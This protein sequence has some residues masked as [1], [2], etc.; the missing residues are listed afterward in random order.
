LS[1]KI[2]RAI[3]K[4]TG[5]IH[6]SRPIIKNIPYLGSTILAM[7]TSLKQANTAV[8]KVLAD[9]FDRMKNQ[10]DSFTLVEGKLEEFQGY[11]EDSV[12]YAD[13][14]R[15]NLQD[16]KYWTNANDC[17]LDNQLD[18]I[19]A[20]VNPS[21]VE[22]ATQIYKGCHGDV[23]IPSVE[24]PFPD[25]AL[26]EDIKRI[27]NE[28]SD[29][30]DKTIGEFL[31]GADYHQC[32]NP[33]LS[34]FVDLVGDISGLAMCPVTGA[35]N[36]VVSESLD[37]LLP[38]VSDD[39]VDVVNQQGE[40][41]NSSTESLNIL[42][43]GM[44]QFG[45]PRFASGPVF[46]AVCD[47]DV[48]FPWANQQ[49]YIKYPYQDI[50]IPQVLAFS[51]LEPPEADGSFDLSEIGGAIKDEC[52]GAAQAFTENIDCC[53]AA[54]I[55][56]HGA[57][58]FAHNNDECSYDTDCHTG[59]CAFVG[60]GYGKR[61]TNGKSGLYCGLDRHCDGEC[62]AL[63]VGKGSFCSDGKEG[64]YCGG[65]TAKDCSSGN[66]CYGP[67]DQCYNGSDGDPCGVHGDCDSNICNVGLGSKCSSGAE[68]TTCT[69]QSDCASGNYCFSGKCYN[70]R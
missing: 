1:K 7:E 63:G 19:V 66:Y 60:S 15:T 69:F 23:S 31:D 41:L 4:V 6:K 17:C 9:D 21:N 24:F 12:T 11:V 47:L 32:C 34:F 30:I 55:K 13:V 29:W 45:I 5:T 43:S 51:K 8:F 28:V 49:Q 16:L 27:A 22:L 14:A 39:I 48:D 44:D 57:F 26:L 52:T 54:T 70:G 10:C 53:P 38:L 67:H 64:D 20:A 50:N 2:E 61:C 33:T 56:V 18:N 62:V 68:G 46:E 3:D 37:V 59:K 36:G 40:K 42:L 58:P 25:L 35:T 65:I